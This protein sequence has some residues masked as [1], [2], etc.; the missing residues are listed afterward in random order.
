MNGNIKAKIRTMHNAQDV[1]IKSIL[2]R[3]GSIKMKVTTRLEYYSQP[4][5]LYNLVQQLRNRYI[6]V[7]RMNRGGTKWI[8]ARY[9]MGYSIETLKDS[10]RRN[11][12]LEGPSAK[13]YYDLAIWLGANGKT[14]LFSFEKHKRLEQKKQ[15]SEG[16]YKKLMQGLDFAI[17]IDSKDLNKAHHD[18]KLIKEVF[19]MYK[20]PYS[21]KFSGTKGFHFVIDSKWI[22][23][24]KKP[25]FWADMFYKAVENLILDENLEYIDTTIYDPRRILKLAY[26]LCNNNGI[27]YVCLPLDDKQ[28][29]N[30]KYEN[31][32]LDNVMKSIKLFQRGL[33]ERHHFLDGD[34]LKSNVMK[35]LKDYGGLDG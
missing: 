5:V 25:I 16:G 3:I 18:A 14:P 13:I 7:R 22:T 31:M 23:L 20:L 21:V 26:S 15:F 29:D 24:D 10:L 9:Y 19:D 35:F 17:D 2:R 1:C 6:S 34:Q 11:K 33:L 12:V 27:E 30:F 32:R 28:F 8:L 4:Y